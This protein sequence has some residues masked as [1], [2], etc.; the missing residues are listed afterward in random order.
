MKHSPA[1]LS[2]IFNAAE[3]TLRNQNHSTERDF[4][5]SFKV[6]KNINTRNWDDNCYYKVI[7]RVTFYSGFR[8]K[9][10]TDKLSAIE[11]AFPDI[12]TVSQYSD[13]KVQQLIS[14]GKIIGNRRKIN[15][16]IENAKE[17]LAIIKHFG[18]FKKYISSFGNLSND[19]N[20]FTLT[21]DLKMRFFFLGGITVY[22][23]LTDIGC[24]VLKP[25]RV[26]CRI[27]T[28]LGL[29]KNEKC[30]WDTVMAGRRIASATGHPIRYV[31]IIFVTYGQVGERAICLSSK[32]K[33]SVCGL[34]RY[35]TYI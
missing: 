25:D 26:L 21:K 13:R 3:K 34:K 15:G 20:L 30:Y 11:A 7:V 27:F 12:E 5:A 35:C 19:E 9:T 18:S 23:F 28:R 10:V 31:D 17:M 8:A 33:C 2:A 22:H 16:L 6:Y 32:P 29:V 14:S 4:D 1:K 24:Q